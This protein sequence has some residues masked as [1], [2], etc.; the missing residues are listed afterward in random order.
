MLKAKVDEQ[1]KAI[2]GLNEIIEKQKL[3]VQNLK[4]T[5]HTLMKNDKCSQ[6]EMNYQ[7]KLKELNDQICNLQSYIKDKEDQKLK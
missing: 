2:R 1:D 6:K 3:H 7:Q 4:L 5:V